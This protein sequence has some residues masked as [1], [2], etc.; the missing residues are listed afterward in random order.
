MATIELNDETY[1]TF[2]EGSEKPVAVRFTATWCGPCKMIAPVLES[3]SE[4]Q[5]SL[6][7]AKV[8][9]DDS[10]QT[11]TDLVIMS[12]PTILVYKD[13]KIEKT[14]VGAKPRAALLKEFE[15]YIN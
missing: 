6:I 12:V 13:G 11:S 14:I 8:D 3:L 10:P 2:V 4:S 5:D 1:K 9:V 7:I 15:E